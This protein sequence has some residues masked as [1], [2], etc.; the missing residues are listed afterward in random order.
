MGKENEKPQNA[1]IFGVGPRAGVGAELCH[2]AAAR[3][4]HVFVNGRTAEKLD[5]VVADIASAG[6]K[7]TALPADL[8]KAD[9]VARALEIVAASEGGLELAIYNA[10]NNRPEP[11]LDVTPEVFESMWQVICFGGFLAAQATIRLMLEQSAAGTAPAK[12]SLFFT[13]ASGSLRGKANFAAFASGK[14]ALRMLVQ[15]LAR[16]FGPQ[17]IHVAHVIIDG[18]IRGEKV[19]S[20]FGD[21]IESLGTDGA[22]Q[23]DAIAEAFFMLHGQHRTAWS[24]E[25]DLRP[26]KENY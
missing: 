10:G 2:Q 9:E 12:Q 21:Y 7:A 1:V 26:F 23:I 8:T 22:L 11:F 4:F 18:V 25:I 16:E 17:G 6:G 5:A 24:Q 13:G 20:R 15:S 3:G 14:G 19:M